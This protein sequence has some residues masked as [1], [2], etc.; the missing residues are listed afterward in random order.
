MMSTILMLIVVGALML[1]AM[2]AIYK[3]SSGF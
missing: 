2:W 3:G 1:F